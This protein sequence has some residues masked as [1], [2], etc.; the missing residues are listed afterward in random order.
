MVAENDFRWLKQRRVCPRCGAHAE[1]LKPYQRRY[2]NLIFDAEA[3]RWEGKEVCG[4]CWT[5]LAKGE[6]RKLAEKMG[7]NLD[8]APDPTRR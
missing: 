8:E 5:S 6:V 7:I 4:R 2:P 3:E 1:Q